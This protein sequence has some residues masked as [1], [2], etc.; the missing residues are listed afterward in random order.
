LPTLG[1]IDKAALAYSLRLLSINYTGPCVDIRRSSDNAVKTFGFVGNN[2]DTA[3][4]SSFVGGGTGFVA[5]LYDQT[6]RGNHAVQVTTAL[7]PQ[8]NLSVA[9]LNNRPGMQFGNASAVCQVTVAN[10]VYNNVF[11]N[12]G[13][14]NLV[15][16]WTGT[17]TAL[18]FLMAKAQPAFRMNSTG[19]GNIGF[20]FTIQATTTAGQ[21]SSAASV[22]PGAHIFDVAYNSSSLSNLPTISIDGSALSF[23]VSIQPVGTINSD[24]ANSVII[25]NNSGGGGGTRGWPGNIGEILIYASQPPPAPIRANQKAYWG[26]P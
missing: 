26:T 16:N 23:T 1:L 21:W 12:G 17:V 15:A 11:A 6:N 2:L 4:I 8:L 3:G 24:S 14:W 9:A 13:W 25:G 5:K 7:Q 18:D 20:A 19:S 22:V 10:A